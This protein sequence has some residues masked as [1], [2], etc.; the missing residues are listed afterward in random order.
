MAE[1]NQK[2]GGASIK[3]IS[4]TQV[5][6]KPEMQFPRNHYINISERLY[7]IPIYQRVGPFNIF[8]FVH[9]CRG[10]AQSQVF[11]NTTQ[12]HPRR[13][14][15]PNRGVRRLSA[16][17]GLVVCLHVWPVFFVVSL[18]IPK[19]FYASWVSII[20]FTHYPPGR[21]KRQREREQSVTVQSPFHF[22]GI[23]KEDFGETPPS[24]SECARFLQREGAGTEAETLLRILVLRLRGVGRAAGSAPGIKTT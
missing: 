17:C 7:N 22:F 8:L 15:L 5:S 2:R 16:A 24:E 18:C 14:F 23:G 3:A 13:S 19:V 6:T 4:V 9:L 11:P 21:A 20:I 10:A 1:F 12:Q